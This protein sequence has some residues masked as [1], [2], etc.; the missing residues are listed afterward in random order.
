MQVRADRLAWDY[1]EY[2]LAHSLFQISSIVSLVVLRRESAPL[3]TG[4][5]SLRT[6]DLEVLTWLYNL[7]SRRKFLQLHVSFPRTARA[8]D[9]DVGTCER[10]R[11]RSGACH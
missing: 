1:N 11:P 8:I 2:L 10:L 7:P 5:Q 4:D 6:S 3:V 9:I